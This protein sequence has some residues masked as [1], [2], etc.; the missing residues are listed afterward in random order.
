[1]ME[2]LKLLVLTLGCTAAHSVND[3][4]SADRGRA[5]LP[6]SIS[7]ILDKCW[8]EEVFG[9]IRSADRFEIRSGHANGAHQGG[10]LLEPGGNIPWDAIHLTQLSCRKSRLNFG[11]QVNF[12][13]MLDKLQNGHCIVVGVIGGSIS[14]AH[15][16]FQNESYH[17]QLINWLNYHYKCSSLEMNNSHAVENMV[18]S[19]VAR[20]TL[21]SATPLALRKKRS[22]RLTHEAQVIPVMGRA[23]SAVSTAAETVGALTFC[24]LLG[25]IQPLGALGSPHGK[26]R[27]QDGGRDA[28]EQPLGAAP[29]AGPQRPHPR[30]RTGS[31]RATSGALSISRHARSWTNT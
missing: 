5:T 10:H 7:S 19:S 29:R 15:G 3:D 24:I 30:H 12:H 17:A 18:A 1:M 2:L 20:L 16:A 28:R 11:S 8:D 25:S 21:T 26:I 23:I 14:N 9:S 31:P 13:A 4:S 6:R 27:A 22:I